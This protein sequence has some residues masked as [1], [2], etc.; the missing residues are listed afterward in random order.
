MN[1]TAQVPP[2][3]NGVQ[4]RLGDINRDLAHNMRALIPTLTEVLI[5]G[6]T[7]EEVEGAVASM[8][9]VFGD[10][11]WLDGIV[12]PTHDVLAQRFARLGPQSAIVYLVV[13][14]DSQ[15]RTWQPQQYLRRLHEIAPRPVFGWVAT[16]LGLGII[17]GPVLDGSEVGDELG[18]VAAE[19]LNGADPSAMQP[20][21]IHPTRL[22]Y[23][24]EPLRRFGIPL[25]RL[26]DGATV[27][28]RPLPVWESYPRTTIA[29]TALIAV[30]LVSLGTLMYSRQRVR[31]A[32]AAQL[33]ATR[34]LL[35][36]QDEERIR[37][38]RDLHDD[39][40]QQMAMLAFDASG[41]RGASMAPSALVDRVHTLIDRT[42]RIAIG[43]HATHIGSMPFREAVSSH[44]A[45]VQ[46]RT[47]LDIQVH[48]RSW[49]GEPPPPVALALFRAM[50]EALQ[51]AVRHAEATQVTVS[52]EASN[53]TMCIE[54]VDDGIGFDRTL[55]RNVGLGLTSMRERMA[56]VGGACTVRSVP[57]G[58]TTVV[59]SAPHEG[60]TASA[61]AHTAAG[62][63][64]GTTT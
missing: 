33:A 58:G 40:C 52:M 1:Q 21:V 26:P 8:R 53:G 30:M 41:S 15:G 23:D 11:V 2:L 61:G 28:N 45:S 49:D 47:G 29:V 31:E 63:A 46:A 9:P 57:F 17:G 64:A 10:R 43:L 22:V 51:N 39:L 13:D 35:Q 27:L 7:D 42:R 62:A 48:E 19:L 3:V 24:W 55:S 4:V 25:S 6:P 16:Y 14:R 20:V 38:A 56:M 18:R 60:N 50:Q 37:I 59:L 5:V 54:V 34:R 44:A 36:A 32:N 12:A